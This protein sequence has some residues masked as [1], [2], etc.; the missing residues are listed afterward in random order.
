MGLLSEC[1]GTSLV[2]QLNVTDF[3]REHVAEIAELRVAIDSANAI[4]D[5]VYVM[6]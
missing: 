5:E 3:V 1:G 6:H 2:V 4:G